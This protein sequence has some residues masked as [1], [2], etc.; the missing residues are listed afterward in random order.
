M[1]SQTWLCAH[2]RAGTIKYHPNAINQNVRVRVAA[3]TP[4][5]RDI[6]ACWSEYFPCMYIWRL[7]ERRGDFLRVFLRVSLPASHA[8][9]RGRQSP[10]GVY[11]Q[12][13]SSSHQRWEQ[14]T[15]KVGLSPINNIQVA[16]LLSEKLTGVWFF[17]LP[18]SLSFFSPS[19]SF[20][21]R[22]RVR[23]HTSRDD[24]YRKALN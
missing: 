14:F 3:R 16:L 1:S 9:L 23:T 24:S 19:S 11:L 10:G 7:L 5:D 12:G 8:C 4:R 18:P 13:A 22:P 20:P 6:G 17:F 2:T 21:R 15:H